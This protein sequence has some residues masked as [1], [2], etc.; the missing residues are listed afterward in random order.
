MVDDENYN[1]HWIWICSNDSIKKGK[2]NISYPSNSS[3]EVINKIGQDSS[4]MPPHQLQKILPALCE[5][6]THDPLLRRQML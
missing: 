2:K 6:R 3:S 1:K 5:V 4:V